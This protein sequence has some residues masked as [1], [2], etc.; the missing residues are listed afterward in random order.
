M[1]LHI[2]LAG[3]AALA[4]AGLAHAG[5]VGFETAS[6]P[7]AGDKPLALTI[8]YP[9]EATE[10]PTPL[11]LYI[12]SVAPGGA[13][14][15]RGHPLVV[16][17]HGTGGSN[18]DH[19]DTARALA[20]A[21]FVVAAPTH[22]GDTQGDRS[23]STRITER[24][25]ELS[26]VIDYMTR[27]WRG[28]DTVDAT[29]IG[30]FGFSSGGFTV[31]GA[32]GGEPDMTRIARHCAEHPHFYDCQLQRQLGGAAGAPAAPAPVAHDPRIRAAVVAAPAL[33]FAFAP[34]GLSK[35]S[36]PVQLWRAEWDTVLPQPYYA[37]VVHGLLPRAEYHV[38]PA[39]EHFDFMAPCS[40]TLAKVAPSICVDSLD[41][42]A[43]H[44]A[45][46]SQVVAFFQK[47]LR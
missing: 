39:A 6:A 4:W 31:L 21:G 34:T 29:K 14:A 27:D 20:A 41:R 30:A 40:N 13:P 18:A 9:T 3:L 32:I 8:W 28:R 38:V 43:F 5:P 17:S 7:V 12:Q 47:T 16:I 45:F 22:T 11:A 37:E 2:W 33:G 23:R 24:P 1:K 15:G 46:N 26:R 42:A 10:R 44:K 25:A 19:Y 36:I 35:V